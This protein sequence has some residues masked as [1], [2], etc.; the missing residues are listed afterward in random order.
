MIKGPSDANRNT[1]PI[2]FL[3]RK[4]LDHNVIDLGRQ[5]RVS[6]VPPLMVYLA[7]G[8]SGLTG[9]VGT[10]FVK[11]YLGLS[12]EFLAALGFWA[13]L[14]WALKMPIG[15]LVDL[16][17]RHKA[18]LIY[19][20]ATLIAAALL[21]MINLLSDREYMQSLWPVENWYVL[22]ALLA[23]VGYVI[24]D[25]VADAMTVEAVAVIDEQG[26]PLPE[27][28]ILAA[29]T[30]MQTLGRVA[31]IGGSL[32]VA[33]VNVAFFSGIETMDE[34]Q[35]AAI[36]LSI[37]RWAL[38][39]PVISI[40]GVVLSSYLRAQEEWRLA[41]HG[42]E[43]EDIER[44]TARAREVPAVNW[45]LLGG[46]LGFALFAAAVGLGGLR[47]SEEIVFAGSLAIVLFLM[48]RLTM[49]LDGKTKNRLYGTAFVIFAFRAVPT[50][51][52]GE[53][54]WMI[55]DL[56]FD[57]Q[58]ISKLSLIASTLTL[59]GMFL[60]R[61][62]MAERPIT[63]I[64]A[65]LTVV[66][67]LLYI[68]NIALYYG[69]HKW[70]A[71]L[72][73]GVVDARFIALVDTAL[74]SPL[75]QIAMIPMLAWIAN[76]APKQL[77]ATYFAVMAAF[78]NLA[79]SLSQL[80]TKWLNQGFVITREVRDAATGRIVVAADYSELGWLLIVVMGLNLAI[81]IAAIVLAK[82]TWLKD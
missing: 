59:L 58:F 26:R 51:G 6:Y 55:D 24:Q 21:I 47:N 23:P 5:M 43:F 80:L 3:L 19:L 57:Q 2:F 71:E 8:V 70:T 82:R 52:A 81:P 38:W 67:G 48:W 62:F 10:F 53:T 20:G 35:K 75:G 63:Y 64:I 14:P 25:T 61:R 33:G 72:T 17:W 31:I 12:A 76:S 78:V 27:P 42:F 37:Y 45:P 68:P 9:I 4:W 22:A 54:W 28:E 11:E 41:A 56:G 29:H 1:A 69:I 40:L 16:L 66:L 50:T 13:M 7:A 39:I 44:L 46:G 34:A 15:H 36:Y 77:K 49:D 73:G 60:F 65:V 30:T 74:E 79:L 32:L 18:G